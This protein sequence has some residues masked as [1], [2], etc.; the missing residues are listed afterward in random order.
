M[1]HHHLGKFNIK[2]WFIK[3]NK[4]AEQTPLPPFAAKRTIKGYNRDQSRETSQERISRTASDYYTP[5]RMRL[6]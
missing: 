6:F 2:S 3:R 1:K 4:R 5:W